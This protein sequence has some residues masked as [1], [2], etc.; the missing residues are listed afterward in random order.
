MKQDHPAIRWLYSVRATQQKQIRSVADMILDDSPNLA[1]NWLSDFSA[2]EILQFDELSHQVRVLEPALAQTAAS[3]KTFFLNGASTEVVVSQIEKIVDDFGGRS[4][5]KRIYD[6]PET[7]RLFIELRD[8]MD[9]IDFVN[10]TQLRYV[11]KVT[12]KVL[13]AQAPKVNMAGLF[14]GLKEK[15]PNVKTSNKR[16]TFVNGEAKWVIS[17]Q[18]TTEGVFRG[19]R[20]DTGDRSDACVLKHPKGIFEGSLGQLF[21]NDPTLRVQAQSRIKFRL[22]ENSSYG[23]LS[24]PEHAPWAPRL[25]NYLAQCSGEPP[26][27]FADSS[28]RFSGIPKEIAVLVFKFGT[29]LCH[30]G[31]L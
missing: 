25:H 18:K 28:L 7:H 3:E 17:T 31:G 6:V 9:I 8:P 29:I 21:W 30:D 13:S 27:R 14:G 26:V 5:R 20:I 23:F 2:L 16:L 4:W 1:D 15:S 22:Q 12:S 24:L 11:G 19:Q 10:K